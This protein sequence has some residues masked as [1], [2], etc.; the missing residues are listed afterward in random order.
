[1]KYKVGDKVKIKSLDWYNENKDRYGHVN[2][3]GISFTDCMKK[4]CGKVLT[5]SKIFSGGYYLKEDDVC[6]NWTDEMIECKIEEETKFG[7][8]KNPLLIKSNANCLTNERVDERPSDNQSV[9]K[10]PEGYI[11]KDDNGN[12]ILT[13]KIILEKKK[14]EYPKTY[15]VCCDV[16][17][18]SPYYNLKYYTYEHFYNEFA[19]SNKLCSLEDKLNILGKLLICRNAY[20]KIAGEEMGLDRPWKPDWNEQTDKF[21]ISNKCNEIYLNNTAWYAQL[22]SFP[23]AKMRDAFYENFKDFIEQCKE[24]L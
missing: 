13:S 21:T 9:W 5:I 16:L 20:W 18:I 24:L 12:E 23:T 17:S 14:K 11:F 6:F 4:H 2:R 7:T 19:T 15:K 3:N 1:M 10:L 8:A 22:L